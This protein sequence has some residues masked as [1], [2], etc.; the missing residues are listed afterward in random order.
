MGFN[1]AFKG[2]K[3][4]CCFKVCAAS[5]QDIG[6]FNFVPPYFYSEFYNEFLSLCIKLG[7]K[8]FLYST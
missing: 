1:S 2:L 6:N 8:S 7:R 3:P 4:H 5:G